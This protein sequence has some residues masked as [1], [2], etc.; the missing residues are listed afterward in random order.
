[1]GDSVSFIEKGIGMIA[2]AFPACKIERTPLIVS[3]PWG[4]ESNNKYANLTIR[5]EIPIETSE[6]NAI[7]L[8]DALQRIEREISAVPHRTA[9][10]AYR[11]REID[12]DIIAIERLPNMSHPRLQLPHPRAAERDFV[13]L[14]MLELGALSLI[15]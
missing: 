15:T 13:R 6:S 12:I 5:T 2:D 7:K 14:P 1:M 4:Y 11:D 10:G 9:D 8:L 3:E